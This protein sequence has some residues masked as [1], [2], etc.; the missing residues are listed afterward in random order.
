[1]EYFKKEEKENEKRYTEPKVYQVDGFGDIIKAAMG[2]DRGYF[3]LEDWIW[4]LQMRP[5]EHW[6]EDEADQTVIQLLHGG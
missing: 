4:T 1:M 5:N 2:G 3:T 6:T